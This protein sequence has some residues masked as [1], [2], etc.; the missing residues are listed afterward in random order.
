MPSYT[1]PRKWKLPKRS[2]A[3]PVHGKGADKGKYF[4]CRN[5]GFIYD[6]QRDDT[7]NAETN[8]GDNHIDYYGIAPEN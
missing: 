1:R 4:R 3:Y 6:K 2:R 5:C 8:A 7:G